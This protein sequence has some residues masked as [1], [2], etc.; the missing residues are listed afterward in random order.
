MVY[1]IWIVALLIT[2]LLSTVSGQ[3][4][5]GIEDAGNWY[6]DQVQAITFGEWN[7]AGN[8]TP[9]SGCQGGKASCLFGPAKEYSGP[10][11]PL[12]EEVSSS[13]FWECCKVLGG[14]F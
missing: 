1:T 13:L 9:F 6:C 7:Y 4:C 3:A 2:T 5:N 12:D 14:F 8:Y 10:L 11:A